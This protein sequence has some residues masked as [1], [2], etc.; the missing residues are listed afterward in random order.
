[1]NRNILNSNIQKIIVLLLVCLPLRLGAQG[2]FIN[3]TSG[4][5][6]NNDSENDG[7][8]ELVSAPNT[9]IGCYVVTNG[10]WV[11]VLPPDAETSADGTYLIAC[12]QAVSPNPN[13]GSGLAY[14]D[15]DFMPTLPIDFDICDPANAAYVDWAAT[16]FTIDNSGAADGDQIVLFDGSG[17]LQDAVQWGGGACLLTADNTTVSTCGGNTSYTLGSPTWN[18]QGNRGLLPAALQ[19][20]G[21]CYQSGVSF[22]MPP[23]SGSLYCDLTN[24]TNT[25]GNIQDSDVLTGCNSSFQRTTLPASNSV[26]DRCAGWQKS[27]H[28]NPGLAN[29]APVD[30]FTSATN[31]IQCTP[32][33]A[34]FSIEVYNYQQVEPTI[35]TSDGKHGSFVLVNGGSPIAWDSI[36]PNTTT[37]TTTL[38]F[39]YTPPATGTY[40]LSFVWDDKTNAP[41]AASNV[42]SN[43]TANP[44]NVASNSDCYMVYTAIVNVIT[45]L[46]TSKTSISCPTDFPVGVV[47]ISSLISGGLNNTYQLYQGGTGSPASGG[48]PVGS[49]NTTG[50][51]Q[52]PTTLTNNLYVIVTDGSGCFAPVQID[53]N[54][55]CRL[56]PVCPETFVN[57]GSTANGS[58]LCVGDGVTLC[59]DGD[60]LP[61]GGTLSWY[62]STTNDPNTA[63]SQ[64]LVCT[65]TIPTPVPQPVPVTIR[66]DNISA[67][68]VT[69]GTPPPCA[70]ALATAGS[71]T[72]PSGNGGVTIANTTATPC[73]ADQHM[74]IAGIDASNAAIDLNEYSQFTY[75]YTVPAGCT[76]DI[77]SVT[78]GHSRSGAGASQGAIYYSLNGGAYTQLGSNYTISNV[79]PCGSFSGS[80]G[81]TGL[82]G[83]VTLGLRIH[84]WAASSTATSTNYRIDDLTV[85]ASV[86]CPTNYYCGAICCDAPSLI[87]TDMCTG[88]TSVP[89]YYFPVISPFTSGCPIAAPDEADAIGSPVNIN[90]SCPTLTLSG[91]GTAC[92]PGPVVLNVVLS[93]GSLA[94]YTFDLIKD[95]VTVQNDV[96]A[97]TFNLTLPAESGTYIIG[98]VKVAAG[99]PAGTC[100]PVV[101]GSATV[102]INALPDVT[103]SGSTTVCPGQ[104]AIITG[105]ITVNS[106]TLPFDVVYAIDG[107]DQPVASISSTTLN[108]S[109]PIALGSGAHTITISSIADA[110]GCAGTDSGSATVNVSALPIAPVAVGDTLCYNGV[111]T[112][113]PT[114]SVQDPGVGITV[115]WYD[116]AAGGAALATG[117][118]YTPVAITP[119]GPYPQTITYYAETENTSGCISATR[120]SVSVMIDQEISFV[121]NHSCVDAGGVAVSDSATFYINIQSITGATATTAISASNG[122]ET[123]SSTYSGTGDV[124]VGPFSYANGTV[125]V[126]LGSGTCAETLTFAPQLCDNN[127]VLIVCNCD[128]SAG[129]LNGEVIPGTFNTVGH[130]LVYLLV[131]R[132]D[133][134]VANGAAPTA[135]EI[136]QSNSTGIF[137]GVETGTYEIYAINY[138]TADAAAITSDIAVGDNIDTFIATADAGSGT[139]AD[140]YTNTTPCWEAIFETATVNISCLCCIAEA[141]TLTPINDICEGL[142]IVTDSVYVAP[143]VD[144]TTDI[145]LGADYFY[146][147]ILVDSADTIEAQNAT[148]TFTAADLPAGDYCVYGISYKDN[149]VDT[150]DGIIINIGQLYNAL[151]AI[152]DAGAT[153]LNAPWATTPGTACMDIS[154]A[155]CFTVNPLPDITVLNDTLCGSGTVDLTT[156]VSGGTGTL[157]YS[158]SVSGP[159]SALGSISVGATT[160]YYVRDSIAAT[161][162]LDIDTLQ[163]IVNPLPDITVLNDTLCGSG[164]V[165]L[166]TLVSGGTGTLGYSTSVSGPFSA[167][168]SVSVGATT[169]YYVRDSIAATGC[170]DI[171][172]LQIIVNP[173]PDITVLND[174][175]CGSGTV[176]LTTLV[177]GGTGS[178]GYST[179]VS[180]PFS[181]LGSVSVGATTT[182]Y[183]R[184][185]IA[186][187]GCRDIDTL[188]IIVNPLPDIT[189]LND[190]LCGS[191]TVDLT[192]LVSGGTGTLG[193]STSVSGPFSAL[194]SVSVGATTTYYVRD[195]IAATG[196]LDIDTL[197]IIVNPLPT[198]TAT[199]THPTS[200]TPPDNVGSITLSNLVN[201][202][203]GVD[204][205]SIDGGTTYNLLTSLTIGSLSSG[206]YNVVLKNAM[207]DCISAT[208]LVTI[209][210]VPGAPAAPTATIDAVC[211]GSNIIVNITSPAMLGANEQF[212][213]FTDAGATTAANPA[214][215]TSS[216]YSPSIAPTSSGNL[217]VR[218]RNTATNC[219]SSLVQI[220]YT[221]NTQPTA[222]ADN[223]ATVCNAGNA[224]SLLDLTALL[225]GADTGGSWAETSSTASG[226]SLSNPASLDFTGVAEGTYTFVYTLAAVSPCLPD[227]AV[228]T[229][230]VESCFDLALTKT[231]TTTGTI[232]LGDTITFDITVYNQGTVTAYDVEITD[233]FNAANLTFVSA[234]SVSSGTTT[235]NGYIIDQ[236]ATGGGSAV[237]TV[238]MIVNPTFTG[239]T[240]IN[241][242]EISFAT[243]VD[244]SIVP[245][246]D[247]DSVPGNETG[248]V[249]DPNDND[250]GATDGSDDYDPAEIR[251]C[252]TCP[253]FPWDGN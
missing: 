23:I 96:S 163:I 118:S 84:G 24:S 228:F 226:V 10:E 60:Y 253:T 174:T 122:T 13:P 160:T 28:P 177:S 184:D 133:W 32:A 45:P 95:G 140:P 35:S 198:F 31:L 30:L 3:E 41:I 176:D 171:D 18:G 85:S 212:E 104:T 80:I 183:V 182:Y 52:L 91:G 145:T 25:G 139:T 236:I 231:L 76:L 44:A 113:N 55:N 103:L 148:G 65:K 153:L 210:A 33:P 50:L 97:S 142:G 192:T 238:T 48:T 252:P 11:I 218:I 7:I 158:T 143:A 214:T 150:E 87:T 100:T 239:T 47:N 204:S 205:I 79:A 243:N 49:S 246:T 186:A 81:S 237:V 39:T 15:G 209:N 132:S 77:S 206:D 195:S 131:Y 68:V 166:T 16:G 109:I 69:P 93:A 98:D 37:G 167:L 149:T 187:T 194:G 213:W 223:V 156:L 244:N 63:T 161:G 173:L 196:C 230:T 137:T 61:A 157:G 54:S 101:L 106:G 178:L 42:G 207:A 180:G 29:T 232:N 172:T 108:I 27:E 6:G 14:A 152:T 189:V 119:T 248:T 56:A 34:T 114:Y 219:I 117:I 19:P 111:G 247:R 202:S 130:T 200:C 5:T 59:F 136:V 222:G 107:V 53:I 251:L 225:S 169:T 240:L 125:T 120:T 229:I 129:D 168:G 224:P 64:T 67:G 159:F 188:Q 138:L 82:T 126:T 73:G 66:W 102:Q 227:T 110:T 211:E 179:S 112:V 116:A 135:G 197:Q 128:G 235:A 43:L 9:N 99:A 90:V 46:A 72:A 241:N 215:S 146:T 88:A 94:N 175:L 154:A 8:V 21:V 115:N 203:V 216:T 170:L 17:S 124:L 40:T 12:S 38:S 245:A 62:R 249:P 201:L 20:G 208:S 51:F 71:A 2:V 74:S 78:F 191:G 83:S 4:D 250:T 220:P 105:A 151:G 86:K 123:Y 144:P 181:A 185:S 162:C 134:D 75:S 190:T 217:W 147:Y 199:P 70:D 36:I 26:V 89:Y 193:Y 57:T 92:A 242:A 141:G 221:V 233:Y 121:L 127:T 22:T 234:T 164:T 1:M 165:D 58:N 155:E